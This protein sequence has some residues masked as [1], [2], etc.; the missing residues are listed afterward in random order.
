M[1]KY[2]A[3]NLFGRTFTGSSSLL[4]YEPYYGLRE[5][6]FSL[7][8]DPRFLYRSSE[9]ARTFDD[10]LLAIRRREGLIVLTGDIGTGKTTLCKAVLEKLDRKT[11]ATFVPDPFIKREDLLKRMLIEFGVMS[12]DELKSD[13]M[14]GASHSDLSYPLYDFLKSLVPLQAF[15]VL[16]I[17]ETQNLALPLLEEIRILSDLESPEKL[18]QVVL[19]GQLELRAKLKLPEMRQFDQRVSARC[20][21][22]ALNR[23]AVAGY[24]SHRLEVAGGT[25]DRVQFSPAAVDAVFSASGGVPRLLNLI[26]DRALY[27]GHLQRKNVIE[28]SEITRS[29]ED[30]GVGNLTAAPVQDEKPKPAPEP[31]AAHPAPTAQAAAPPPAQPAPAT[32]MAASPASATP[33]AV[34]P[35][36]A[37]PAASPPAS[38]T[39]ATVPA[40]PATPAAAPPAP[41]TPTAAPPA[42][43]MPAAAPP[44]PA[45]PTAAPPAPATPTAAPPAPAT[46]TAAPP[47]AA[48]LNALLH[49]EPAAQA[50]K[51]KDATP[52]PHTAPAGHT[53][54]TPVARPTL[55]VLPPGSPEPPDL[56]GLDVNDIP[57]DLHSPIALPVAR[58]PGTPFTPMLTLRANSNRALLDES[59]SARRWRIRAL[60][61]AF[62]VGAAFTFASFVVMGEVL[63][64][65]YYPE[66]GDVVL[67]WPEPPPPPR[68]AR[69]SV[70]V[71]VPPD[72]LLYSAAVGA[73]T[74]QPLRPKV[75]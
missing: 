56:S 52:V 20:S 39:P 2:P 38:A 17:D 40:A 61:V 50:Q 70:A 36:P 1:D 51:V 42:P 12:L 26:C 8:T 21:L 10:L 48:S 32:P 43:A 37:T 34:P 73:I 27:L 65:N 9:H 71:D 69:P 11:F 25:D 31:A 3:P 44:A 63:V 67:A 41:A 74:P 14:R 23:E 62:A 24:V 59:A 7:S 28:P 58:E 5:K 46:P 60:R 64:M 16:I 54:P 18:L 75:E 33:A 4:T 6:P 49:A 53:A 13:K 57:N 35:A 30:L 45:M 47:A 19:V 22:Q 72:L 55:P 15:A 66:P 68:M 29:I